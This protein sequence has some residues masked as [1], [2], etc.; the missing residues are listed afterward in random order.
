MVKE[1]SLVIKGAI[2]G[3]QSSAISVNFIVRVKGQQ[4]NLF[5]ICIGITHKLKNYT[6]A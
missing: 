4:G 2:A 3:H 6:I 1:R 5:L